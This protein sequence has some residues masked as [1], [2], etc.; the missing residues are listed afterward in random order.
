M[1]NEVKVFNIRNPLT[2]AS[3]GFD[4]LLKIIL[5]KITKNKVKQMCEKF[6]Q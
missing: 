6:S 1:T 5:I 2:P 3:C 4:M